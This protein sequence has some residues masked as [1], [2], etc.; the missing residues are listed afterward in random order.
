MEIVPFKMEPSEECLDS[1]VVWI[2]SNFYKLR[3]ETKNSYETQPESD[4]SNVGNAAVW[5]HKP[6]R[7]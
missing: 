3:P 6:R 7:P 2:C 1:A 5:Q 4:K